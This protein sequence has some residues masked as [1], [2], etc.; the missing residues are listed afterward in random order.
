MYKQ[1][2]L[3]IYEELK[4]FSLTNMSHEQGLERTVGAGWPLKVS[5]DVTL[6]T[7]GSHSTKRWSARAFSSGCCKSRHE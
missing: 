7:V 6:C 2:E 5:T 3:E 1:G 4:V